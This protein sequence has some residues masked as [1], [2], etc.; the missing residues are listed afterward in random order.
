[1]SNDALKLGT[2]GLV[3]ALSRTILAIAT[4]GYIDE[5]DEDEP[6]TGGNGGGSGLKPGWGDQLVSYP[7]FFAVPARKQPSHAELYAFAV[8][9]GF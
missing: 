5:E 6:S 9:A 7:D 2:L 8:A 4:L 1:V 3:A